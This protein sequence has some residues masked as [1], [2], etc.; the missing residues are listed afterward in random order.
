[1]TM[2]NEWGCGYAR[3]RGKQKIAFDVFSCPIT[4][5]AEDGFLLLPFVEPLPA[6]PSC[7]SL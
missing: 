5:A 4:T 2:N 7:I 3:M 1:L 6:T